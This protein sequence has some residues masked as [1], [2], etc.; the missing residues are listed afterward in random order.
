MR[1]RESRSRG[2]L[3]D[4]Q[5]AS[6]KR[7]ANADDRIR[8]IRCPANLLKVIPLEAKFYQVSAGKR[9]AATYVATETRRH[10]EGLFRIQNPG[11]SLCLG[12]LVATVT[13]VQRDG[14]TAIA[15]SGAP[16]P[17][18]IFIGSAMTSAPRT[19]QALEVGQVLER[20]NV[21]LV[22]QPVRFVQRRL[23]EVDAGGVDADRLDRTVCRRATSRRRD[24][25]RE[26][27]AWRPPPRPRSAVPRYRAASGQRLRE[28]RAQ[29]H[30]RVR[31]ESRRACSPALRDRRPSPDS[32][33]ARPRCR[34]TSTTTAGPNKPIERDLI[35][36]LPSLREVH[37][38]V[39]M[40]AA[41]LG[42]EEVVGGVVIAAR[43]HAV[44]H[45]LEPKRVG[46][47]P[48]DGFRIVVCERSTSSPLG[49]A[50]LSRPLGCF[51]EAGWEQRTDRGKNRRDQQPSE[52]IYSA[53]FA[54]CTHPGT[55]HSG[56]W[57][58]GTP[59]IIRRICLG[60][61][62]GNPDYYHRV[63]DCQWACPAH[64]NVPEYIRLIA[65]GRF[66]DAYMLNRESNVFPGHPRPHLRSAVRAGVPAHPRR[67]QAG[68][69]LPAEARRRGSH[70]GDITHLLPTAPAAEE[71][72][73]GRADRRRP[74]LADRRQ[75]PDAARLSGH[76]LREA[77]AARRAD[78]H[79][80]P[81]VPP[82]RAGAG[83]GDRLHH[84]HGRRRPLQ[85][86][87]RQP[88]GAARHRASSTR[89]SSAAARRRA[90]SSRFPGRHDTDQIFIGIEWLES[91]HF[92]H[93]DSVGKRVLIIGVGN[94]AMDC[95][96]SAKRL[97]ATDVKV[98]ARKTRK[99]FKASPW[100]LEDAEEEERRD[101]R[102]PPAGP[103]HHRER[104][105]DRH[106]VRQV[107]SRSRS[108]AS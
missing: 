85:H 27:A 9:V 74:G 60:P 42:G 21:A 76:D 54:P 52:L 29:Q 8:I 98:I 44:G 87:G 99:Y 37:R 82:A 72:Q 73:E 38:R 61:D 5:G 4:R 96:R 6:Q 63:V 23:A 28:S 51:G 107:H 105:A 80:H 40:R 25:G 49:N 1:D 22:E 92:G 39:E 104:Q 45:F 64:T 100:E 67:R 89:C 32:P 91:I 36:R 88:E 24:A 86:A 16:L 59:Y 43:R 78:A 81:G 41:V 90:R 70:R 93:V 7:S 53:R 95:C 62:V 20:G 83:R 106:G 79:Q 48:E 94:T 97:G 19:R 68:R 77:A 11:N 57:H 17:P 3:R 34:L 58:R 66:T 2:P 12:V 65:Q 47:R 75:R 13:S 35:D 50:P 101:H 55:R 69:D 26:N 84:R 56:T 30:D 10:R 18:P 102:E 108:T 15:R 46:G 71:R 103:L 33:R 31:R 14:R